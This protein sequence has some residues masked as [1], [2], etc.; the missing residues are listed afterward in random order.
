ELLILRGVANAKLRRTQAALRDLGRALEI[1][2]DNAEALVRR[3]AVN[4][5][6]KRADAALEDLNQAIGIDAEMADAWYHRALAQKQKGDLEASKA[7]VEKALTLDP[8]FA[9]AHLLKASLSETEGDT[10][11]AIAGYRK[12]L[13]LDPFSQEARKAF[14]K[15][16]GE[17]ADSVVKPLAEP[18]S[19]WEVYSPAEGRFVAVN[20]QYP[21]ISVL[22]EMHGP[23][24]AEIL[25]WTPLKDW[26]RNIGLLRY[27][28]GDTEKGAYEYVAILDLGAA[29]VVAIE[30]YLW[31]EQ[32]ARWEWTENT[33]TV[34]D[35]EG[36]ASHYELRR[37]KPVEQPRV[38]SDDPWNIFGAP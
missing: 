37:P 15:A 30:P 16:S 28:A 34:T 23:G 14:E 33:V 32:K 13:E 38:A 10:E 26:L 11:A 12:A 36:L 18:V 7:D 20:P 19:G 29:K 27:K 22:L 2:P 35:P 4:L 3:A 17:K 31:G 1:E 21:K 6:R 24:T 25:E 8:S 9:E 5:E